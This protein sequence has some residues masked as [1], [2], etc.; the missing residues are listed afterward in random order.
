MNSPVPFIYSQ[1]NNSWKGKT[2]KQIT[3]SIDK[4]KIIDKEN[5][6]DINIFFRS[7]P[8]SIYRRNKNLNNNNCSFSKN[9]ISS[10]IDELNM[11]GSTITIKDNNINNG[12]VNILDINLPSNLYTPTSLNNNHIQTTSTNNNNC[13]SQETNARRRV[14]SAGMIR[15]KYSDDGTNKINYCINTNQYLQ[16]RTKTFEKNNYNYIRQGS[17]LVKPGDSLSKS[18]IYT[19]NTTTQCPKYKLTTEITFK[20][21]WIDGIYYDVIVPE[22]Y[23]SIE[24]FNTILQ[25]TMI[26]NTHHFINKS[27]KTSIFLLNFSFNIST[28]TIELQSLPAN[29]YIYNNIDYEVAVPSW[30]LLPTWDVPLNTLY[31]VIIVTDNKIGNLIGFSPGAYPPN[32][33]T[34]NNGFLQ[35]STVQLLNN[36]TAYIAISTFESHLFSKYVQ[37]FYK[38]SNSQFAT[39]GA[40]S[41]SSLVTRKKYDTVNN[42][43]IKTNN[44]LNTGTATMNALAYGGPDSTYTVKDK[45]GYPIKQTPVISKYT[46]KLCA[47]N[48][49]KISN[50]I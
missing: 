24:D 2:F 23:Y 21:Q 36:K 48:V 30:N 1:P 46:G 5:D 39:Q 11:P 40:V 27:T 19:S 38:P 9:R 13:L 22:G 33:I 18:N 14:R 41:S 44:L 25:Q 16:S 42:A 8:L 12:L 34:T 4:N 10:S 47:K 20:Y 26:S 49:S 45:K 43:A 7:M 28:S 3:S 17:A 37:I 35:Q 15:K 31:P 32:L 29:V 6:F 50:M